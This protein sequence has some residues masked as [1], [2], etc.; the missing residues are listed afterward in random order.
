MSSRVVTLKSILLNEE[1][2]FTLDNLK[3]EFGLTNDKN[4]IN[5]FL[6]LLEDQLENDNFDIMLSEEG[7]I[8]QS[9]D[10]LTAFIME[11]RRCDVENV[12]EKVKIIRARLKLKLAKTN[13]M[14]KLGVGETPSFQKTFWQ[15]F[16]A[17]NNELLSKIDMIQQN[18]LH[19]IRDNRYAILEDVVFNIKNFYLLQTILYRYPSFYKLRDQNNQ[20]FFTNLVTYYV[21]LLEDHTAD[22]DDIVYYNAV[23]DL[24]SKH[25][26]VEYYQSLINLISSTIDRL[27]HNRKM[28]KRIRKQRLI[29]LQHFKGKLMGDNYYTKDVN[30]L[31]QKYKRHI[32]IPQNQTETMSLYCKQYNDRYYDFTDKEVI[33][34]DPIGTIDIDDALSLERLT[35]NN[36]L[37]GVYISDVSSYVPFNSTCDIEAFSRGE[38]IYSNCG[39]I[40]SMLPPEITVNCCSLLPGVPKKVI[41]HFIEI[42][43]DGFV[44]KYFSARG[45]INLKPKNRLSYKIADHILTRGCTDKNIYNVLNN[46]YVLSTKG[47]LG[48]FLVEEPTFCES[49]YSGF[50]INKC[51]VLINTLIAQSAKEQG[52]PFLYRAYQVK[53]SDCVFNCMPSLEDLVSNLN[54]GNNELFIRNMI[55]NSFVSAY[56]TNTATPHEGLM[57]SSYTH[58]TAPIRRFADL[59]NQRLIKLFLIDGVKDD[60]LNQ[61]VDKIVEE[62]ADKLNS[63]KI[64]VDQYRNDYA[65]ILRRTK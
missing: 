47:T 15:T 11:D 14:I 18:K 17:L 5:L 50:L 60:K 36:Y 37:L 57:L 34:I 35:N 61:A 10:Y 53:E 45:L 48:G 27:R 33:T 6:K 31:Y 32:I 41:A 64:I 38:T 26:E 39:V 4:L 25:I 7:L 16:N 12:I 30:E 51:M 42:E 62:V 46:L 29:F 44:K 23:T 43:P 55:N 63:N 58:T 3:E 49:S 59:L 24:F 52:F 40:S 22:Y 2:N 65:H 54:L 19:S 13:E 1:C 21:K 8:E 20:S 9:Y 28:E 56:Y